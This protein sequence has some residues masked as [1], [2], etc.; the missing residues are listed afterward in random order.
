MIMNFFAVTAVLVPKR[1]V[2]ARGRICCCILIPISG[3]GKLLKS[4]CGSAVLK[5]ITSFIRLENIW[6]LKNLNFTGRSLP[7]NATVML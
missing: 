7:C 3:D 4:D 2:N 1:A 5:R 6:H